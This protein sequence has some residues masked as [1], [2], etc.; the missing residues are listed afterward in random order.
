MSEVEQ[1]SATE[2]TLTAEEAISV[3]KSVIDEENVKKELQETRQ[4]LKDMTTEFKSVKETLQKVTEYGGLEKGAEAELKK[5]I[6]SFFKNLLGIDKAGI[7]EHNETMVSKGLYTE[8]QAKSINTDTNSCLV[9]PQFSKDI[10]K[11]IDKEGGLEQYT[12]RIKFEGKEWNQCQL[13]TTVEAQWVGECKAIC[14]TSLSTGNFKLSIGKLGAIIVICNDFFEYGLSY[15]DTYRLITEEFAKA[16]KSKIDSMILFGDG[17]ANFG[18]SFGITEMTAANGFTSATYASG[19]VNVVTL[20][21][22]TLTP[23]GVSIDDLIDMI[24]SADDCWQGENNKWIMNKKMLGIIAKMKDCCGNPLLVSNWND[25]TQ[26]RNLMGDPVITT[27]A[28][29]APTLTSADAGK[30][31]VIYGDLSKYTLSYRGGMNIKTSEHGV[32]ADCSTGGTTHNLFTEDKLGIRVTR[33][34]GGGSPTPASFSILQTAV[35]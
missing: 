26:L 28:M 21:A 13:L 8:M 22:G 34:A 17:T 32:I 6:V 33:H 1:K 9:H 16:F 2:K 14:E 12:N 23:D 27:N 20:D 3:A 5:E 7:R 35:V 19:P 31:F 11:C 24:L 25:A 30:T 18:G 4:E 10:V 15:Q 29:P